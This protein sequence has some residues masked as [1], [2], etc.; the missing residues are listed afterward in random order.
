MSFAD[1][2]YGDGIATNSVLQKSKEDL[3]RELRECTK[4]LEEVK[5][6]LRSV[7]S[8]WDFCS[9]RRIELEKELKEMKDVKE[10]ND[11]IIASMKNK[12]ELNQKNHDEQIAKIIEE[13]E[14]KMSVLKDL[15]ADLLQKAQ[16]EHEI[17]MK[18]MKKEQDRKIKELDEILKKTKQESEAKQAKIEKENKILKSNQANESINYQQEMIRL[19]EEHQKETEAMRSE[20]EEEKKSMKNKIEINQKNHDEQIAKIIEEHEEKMTVLKY[21]NAESMKTA[22][23]AHEVKMK[24]MKK[25]QDQKIKELDVILENTKQKSEAEQATI[26]KEIKILKSKQINES[27]IYQQEIGRLIAEHQKETE[28]IRK[29]NEAMKSELKEEKKSELSTKLTKAS[30]RQITLDAS[31]RVFIQ[32]LNIT[33]TVQDASESL[34]F[35]ELYCSHESPE[36]FECAIA[37]YLDELNELKLKFKE[38]VFHFR[39]SAINEQNV[40]QEIRNVC[41][42]Y[43]QKSEELMM[44][45]SLLELCLHLPTAV[46]N[47]KIFEIEEFKKK[48]GKLSEEMKI[49]RDVV[50]MKL[51]AIL[52]AILQK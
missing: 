48:A 38:R 13:L 18:I 32:F 10:S 47:K 1:M 14:E 17:K 7:N 30:N 4:E 46:E 12:I 41:K 23:E 34:E 42:S 24:I 29:E 51:E 35:I 37:I 2:F 3:R 26:E 31:N 8:C 21:K 5:S 16:E 28:A 50:Q 9:M 15:N 52:L 33:R 27:R 22:R 19:I 6:Q 11:R 39:Q 49:T 43:L 20:L 40:H 25:E 44:S 45:E 36:N